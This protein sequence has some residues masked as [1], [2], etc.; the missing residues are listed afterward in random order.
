MTAN[1]LAAVLLILHQAGAERVPAGKLQWTSNM[2]PAL[3]RA[4]NMQYMIRHEAASGM[5]FSLT[6]AGYIAIGKE[7]PRH[8]SASRFFRSFFRGR[9]GP[10]QDL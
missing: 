5:T 9:W 6:E 1:D 3:N 2:A 7:V 4:L 10:G 8:M